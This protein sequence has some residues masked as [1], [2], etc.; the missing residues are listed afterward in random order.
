[1]NATTFRR[2][3]F[4]GAPLRYSTWWWGRFIR[5]DGGRWFDERGERTNFH[6]DNTGVGW[7]A[8]SEKDHGEHHAEERD[9]AK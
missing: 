8:Y 6:P 7:E 5:Y 4:A 3:K 1:M 2:L 9:R